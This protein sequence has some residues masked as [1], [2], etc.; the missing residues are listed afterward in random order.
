MVMVAIY[1]NAILVSPIKNR[2]DEDLQREYLEP[3]NRKKEAGIA[4]KKNV[5]NNECSANMKELIRKECK[6]EL[7]PP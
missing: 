1:S 4:V 3:L 5:L 7:V 2:K 6:L